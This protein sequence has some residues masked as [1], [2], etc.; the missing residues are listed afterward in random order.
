MPEPK[1]SAAHHVADQKRLR[2]ESLGSIVPTLTI[3]SHPNPE[4]IGFQAFLTGLAEGHV[5]PFS[6]NQLVFGKGDAL[7]GP[8]GD[9]F[10]S[11]EPITF[12]ND[13]KGNL[14]LNLGKSR[15]E[16]KVGGLTVVKARVI[17]RAAL[18]QGI[19]VALADRM[20]FWL[21]LTQD[22]VQPQL[23]PCFNL[24]GMS[25]AVNQIRRE[26][27][28][29]KDLDVTLLLR[30]EMGSGKE[31]VAKVIHAFG[32]RKN[33]PFVVVRMSALL[34]ETA[35]EALF[36]TCLVGVQAEGA[37]R[38][39][40]DQAEGGTLYLDG[41]AQ[42]TPEVQQMLL[43]I[44]ETGTYVPIGAKTPKLFQGRIMVGTVENLAELVMKGS[45]SESLFQKLAGYEIQIPSLNSYKEDLGLLFRKFA[46]EALIE[47]NEPA[48]VGQSGTSAPAWLSPDIMVPLLSYN[49]PDN[50]RQLR[51]VV[52]ELVAGNR[53]NARLAWTDSASR[54]LG[55]DLQKVLH[56]QIYLGDKDPFA[57]CERRSP[58]EITD[59]QLLEAL[60][61]YRWNYKAAAAGLGISRT[62]F[63]ILASRSAKIRKIESIPNEQLS[64]AWESFQGDLDKVADFFS[65]S[66]TALKQ[67]LMALGLN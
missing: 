6:R 36:G 49:W 17:E 54:I 4:K 23:L 41:I 2:N 65:V 50:V 43:K 20:T 66:K 42:S 63:Y 56:N 52:R 60:R 24:A 16:C 25:H 3:T 29:V 45:F 11:R 47:A 19:S 9:P 10:L 31:H 38:G 58:G 35:T 44:L 39:F 67:R 27:Q 34:P 12:S 8:L 5:V 64:S 15:A 53:G 7:G 61:R 28:R 18:A 48:W 14:N 1:P 51:N 30:G 32:I 46:N 40:F 55:D 59:H 37:A 21:H 33:R 13:A 22:Q 26:I 62:S 57:G